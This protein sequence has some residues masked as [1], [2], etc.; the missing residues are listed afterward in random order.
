M[1]IGSLVKHVNIP[2]GGL[3]VV[4][5]VRYSERC[6]TKIE[7][8]WLNTRLAKSKVLKMVYMQDLEIISEVQ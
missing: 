7:V 8:N 6:Y 1:K 5:D 4:V 3:G 2:S